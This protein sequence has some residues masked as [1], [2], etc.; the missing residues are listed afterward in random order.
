MTLK[1]VLSCLFATQ[2]G[3]TLELSVFNKFFEIFSL[4]DFC[5][6]VYFQKGGLVPLI[7][8]GCAGVVTYASRSKLLHFISYSVHANLSKY[9]TTVPEVESRTQ[10]SRPR[11]R[12]QKKTRGQGQQQPFRGQTLSRPSIGMLEAKDQG[13]KRKCSPKK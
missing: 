6:I 13:H 8:P 1:K 7:P 3:I 11:P 5:E 10:G 9:T 4:N 12:T 2:G